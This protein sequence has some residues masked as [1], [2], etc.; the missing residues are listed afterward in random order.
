MKQ[1][2]EKQVTIQGQYP[3]AATLLTP[4]G[5][6][7]F[8][9]VIIVPGSGDGDR[10]GNFKR[11]KL[12]PNIYK[13]VAELIAGLGFITLRYDKRGAGESGGNFYETGMTDLV[14][15]IES[16]LSFLENQTRAEKMFLLGHSEGCTLITAAN[17]RRPV[18]GLIFL[19]GAAESVKDALE[20]QR[21]LLKDEIMDMGGLKGKLLRLIKVDKLIDK[22][23]D[24]LN[25]KIL[26]SNKPVIRYQFQKINAKWFKEHF[27]YNVFADLEKVTC[28][29]LAVT[30]EKDLQVTPG[31]AHNLSSYVQGPA[32]SHIVDNMDHL[33]KEAT[34][35]PSMLTVSKEY[36]KNEN[37]PLHPEFQR[38]LSEWLL[39][40]M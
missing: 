39:E 15:D 13:D 30:G 2:S 5:P 23:A 12:F 37:K 25:K 6:G 3:L 34:N 24:N 18:D 16:C 1:I 38:I 28:P 7:P 40:Q 17:A 11:G 21:Q 31:K 14:D 22:Q 4:E 8:P 9:A 32:E 36:K 35:T 20:R 29:S 19:S 10:D 26:S 27:T 33:L